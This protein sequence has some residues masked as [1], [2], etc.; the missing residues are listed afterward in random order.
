M[1]DVTVAGTT[2]PSRWKMLA[3]WQK[4]MVSC[5]AGIVAIAMIAG[6]GF[7][8]AF[9][10]ATIPN[11]NADFQSSVSR[12]YYA[13]SKTE[14]AS[15][16]VHNRTAVTAEKIPR[17]MKDAMVAAEDRTFWT[18]AG[19]SPRGIARAVAAMVTDQEVQGGSTITQQ[20]VRLM[21]LTSERTVAR[22]TKEIVLALKM[23]NLES[24]EEIL[25]N[26]LNTVYFSRGSYGVQAAAQNW[27]GKDAQALT[28]PEAAV[29][30]A[31]VQ[32][33][34]LL[35]P[36][37]SADNM[38]RLEARYGYVLSGM[39]AEKSIT[40][41]QYDQYRDT[42]P[43]LADTPPQARYAGPQGF[44]VHMAEKELRSLNFTDAQINGGGLRV[45]TTFD[46]AAQAAAAQAAQT[47][48]RQATDAANARGEKGAGIHAA[49]ASVDAG[50][51]GLIAV[52]GGG[53][54]VTNSRN[55]AATPRMTGSTFKAFGLIAGL[56]NGFGLDS[57]LQGD[58]FTPAGESV[59]VRN[60]FSTQYGSVTLLKATAES[61]NTAFVD[62]V[63]KMEDGPQKVM[64][65][66]N[67]A[68][69]PRA[70]GWDAGN[71]VV[72]G[73]AE[74]S[75]VDMANAY[76]TLAN[77]G[78]R[79]GVHVIREVSDSAGQ[80]LYKSDSQGKDTVAKG[81]AA[82]TTYALQSVVNEGT[83][84]RA[85]ALGRPVAGKTGTAGVDSKI[86]SA[87]FVA[88]TKQ[89]S[90]AV[91]FVAG[92]DGTADL[93]PYREPGSPTFFGAGYPLTTWLDYMR[94]ATKDQP[95]EGF[96]ASSF[97]RKQVRSA[98]TPVAG[99][100]KAP[101]PANAGAGQERAP[102][103]RTPAPAQQPAASA[104][105]VVVAT[106]TA[107]TRRTKRATPRPSQPAVTAAPPTASSGPQPTTDTSQP[108]AGPSAAP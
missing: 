104:T 40:Q 70:G 49:I 79:H 44:L 101:A 97:V 95:V 75:P 18:N 103:Q 74:A 47:Y 78:T 85:A 22:K 59:P 39:L 15:L 56:R 41:E 2:T 12:L 38:P 7:G 69:V 94:V 90:T 43:K 34:S 64:Q 62:M 51:G 77:S 91:M 48:Q 10:T 73:G 65:A 24:K 14:L 21:Y 46:V 80:V 81:V 4:A 92:D 99:A 37:V 58:T 98:Q 36:N 26:Y 57:S 28:M 88:Y 27:F 25:T 8:A 68:G 87:W 96:D 100:G 9:F 63:A 72:L 1:E 61:I 53:D 19:V 83:G 107:S 23:D 45:T 6:L 20:Y 89:I 35:D 82:D 50:T 93:E 3:R 52:Y 16:A 76:A 108:P 17:S 42:M 86:A 29:L 60:E 55:W 11:P 71:R 31:V 84:A 13:D 105:P 106:P 33:P 102:V 30:A 32:N 54:F 67:D 5:V 66:A